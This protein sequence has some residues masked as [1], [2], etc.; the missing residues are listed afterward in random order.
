MS[1]TTQPPKPKRRWYQFSLRTLMA[2][3]LVASASVGWVGSEILR[4]REE[5]EWLRTEA[6]AINREMANIHTGSY[7][8]PDPFD[9]G[10]LVS[11][12]HDGPPEELPRCEILP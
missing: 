12:I 6:R 3:V 1:T 2:F 9:A 11:V 10:T 4:G 8:G 5:R 7:I